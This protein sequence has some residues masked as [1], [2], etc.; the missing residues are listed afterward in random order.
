MSTNALRHNKGKPQLS[1]LLDAP[2]AM[3]GLAKQFELGTR[4]YSRDNWKKGF[5]QNELIDSLLRHLAPL[6]NGVYEEEEFDEEGNSI[7]FVNHC[8]ALLWNAVVLSEQI[9][10]S[11]SEKNKF[12]DDYSKKIQGREHAA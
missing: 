3:S 10:R 6:Q 1:Y 12:L 8:D 4:K 2:L 11:K 7:G 9:H 5:P